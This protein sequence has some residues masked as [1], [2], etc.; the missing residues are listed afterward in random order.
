M[1]QRY[2]FAVIGGGI[3][4]LATAQQLEKLHQRGLANGLRVKWSLSACV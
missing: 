4:G 3:V 1:P 2:D